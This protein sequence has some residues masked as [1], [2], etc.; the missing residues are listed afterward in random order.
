MRLWKRSLNTPTDQNREGIAPAHLATDLP[1][2]HAWDVNFWPEW[3]DPE[4]PPGS[5]SVRAYQW[6]MRIE[7]KS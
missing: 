6:A 3:D 5:L 1:A 2:K 4:D 7:K